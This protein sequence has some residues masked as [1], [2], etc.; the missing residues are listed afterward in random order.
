MYAAAVDP[1]RYYTYGIM[2]NYESYKGVSHREFLS[3]TNSVI[4][5]FLFT[6]NIFK[7]QKRQSQV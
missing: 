1:E 4:D 3:V 7:I 5:L 2:Y 6:I